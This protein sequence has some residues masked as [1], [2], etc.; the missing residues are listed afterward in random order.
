V[1]KGK[2]LPLEALAP[3]LLTPTDLLA[4]LDWQ[5]VFGNDRPVELEVGFGKGAFLVESAADRP[6]ANF[7]GVELDR[8]LQLYVAT[9]LAKRQ[10]KNVRLVKADA[11]AFLR[12]FV[13]SAS[14]A[15]VH[16]Y[17]PDP[18]WKRRHKKRRLFTHDFAEQVARVLSPGGRLHL[19]TDVEDYFTLMINLVE[20]LPWF[21]VVDKHM[22]NAMGDTPRGLTNFER[23]SLEQGGSVWRASFVRTS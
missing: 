11:L 1:R 6:E 8:A 2:R 7:L 22:V 9:R 15:A 19:A 12:V 3:Y 18:W 4:P 13:P 16:V 14:L 10:L 21:Q 20:S 17:C 5:Q 23:K